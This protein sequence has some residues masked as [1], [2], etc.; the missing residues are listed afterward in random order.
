MPQSDSTLTISVKP[1]SLSAVNLRKLRVLNETH[2]N[3]S[4]KT[5]KGAFVQNMTTCTKLV[6][7]LTA[8]GLFL[9]LWYLL[10]AELLPVQLS[11]ELYDVVVPVS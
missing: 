11:P 4:Q 9:V 2:H 3:S 7:C 8:V 5:A 1:P 6:Q 10:V